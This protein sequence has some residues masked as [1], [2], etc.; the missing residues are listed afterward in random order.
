MFRNR[1]MRSK[2]TAQNA[3][4]SLRTSQNLGRHGSQEEDERRAERLAT[5]LSLA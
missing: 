2:V 1:E 4:A 5:H 3:P